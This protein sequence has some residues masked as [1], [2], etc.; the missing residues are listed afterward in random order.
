MAASTN[1]ATSARSPEDATDEETAAATDS[2]T[3]RT[4]TSIVPAAALAPFR[5]LLLL[6]PE[7]LC[8]GLAELLGHLLPNTAAALSAGT[9][10]SSHQIAVHENHSRL[11]AKNWLARARAKRQ[12][13]RV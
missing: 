9:A 2:R 13:G 1:W 5:R 7:Q 6:G 11:T 12:P 3:L 8:I 4:W 10:A